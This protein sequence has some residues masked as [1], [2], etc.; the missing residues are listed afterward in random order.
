MPNDETLIDYISQIL[1]ESALQIAY[2]SSLDLVKVYPTNF[3]IDRA[4]HCY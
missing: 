2:Y 1:N 3:I 4:C